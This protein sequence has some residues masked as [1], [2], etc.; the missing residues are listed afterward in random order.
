MTDA[1]KTGRLAL[2]FERE[3]LHFVGLA[4]LLGLAVWLAYFPTVR[5][6]S[7]WGLST[8]DWYRIAI[9]IPIVH[10]VYVW[11]VWRLELHRKTM[12]HLMGKAAFPAYCTGFTIIGI[13]RIVS[14]FLVAYSNGGSFMPAPLAMK[15]LAV[16]AL[17]PAVYLFYSVRRYFGFARA[18]GIDHFDP[19]YRD[20]PFEKRGIFR[21]S[22]NGMY[23]F[24]FL[25]LWVPGLWWG[26]AAGLAVA[27]FNHLYIWV[28][29]YATELPDIRRIYGQR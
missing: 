6:G 8:I 22:P 27:L 3:W 28:H 29:Y 20:M 5:Q 14:V 26:S 17:I 15:I 13:A 9:L 25:L 23:V 7:L 16:V 12:T 10:Q 11:L 19:A 2:I 4:V 24:G 18:F 21:L 1:S